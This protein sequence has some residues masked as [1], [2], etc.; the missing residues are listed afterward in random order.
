MGSAPGRSAQLPRRRE[1]CREDLCEA[2]GT[3][4]WL[5]DAV[6]DLPITVPDLPVVLGAAALLISCIALLLAA[7]AIRVVRRQE[8]LRIT[9]RYEE[10]RAQRLEALARHD[11]DGP[12]FEAG[13]GS[14]TGRTVPVRIRMVGGPGSVAVRVIPE[15]LWCAGL[16]V[17]ASGG[18]VRE[19]VHI[20]AVQPGEQF[21]LTAHLVTEPGDGLPEQ[22]LMTSASRRGVPRGHSAPVGAAGSGAARAWP[23]RNLS[24]GPGLSPPRLADPSS[25]S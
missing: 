15:M 3:L 13:R 19:S 22:D 17:G 2:R 4:Q 20:P 8:R 25:A 23:E 6:P 18:P 14:F 21:I 10:R 7:F 11:A 1:E 16:A 9:A 12:T 24:R 5:G